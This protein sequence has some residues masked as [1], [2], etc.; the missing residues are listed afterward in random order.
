[1]KKIFISLTVIFIT[2]SFTGGQTNSEDLSLQTNSSD[3]NAAITIN[4]GGKIKP[5]MQLIEDSFSS[6]DS[7]LLP[8]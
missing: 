5:E 3:K 8:R 2:V 7:A 4:N 1:M 6:Q